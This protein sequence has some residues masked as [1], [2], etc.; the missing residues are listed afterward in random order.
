MGLIQIVNGCGMLRL[1]AVSNPESLRLLPVDYNNYS[2]Y[3]KRVK[4]YIRYIADNNGNKGELPECRQEDIDVTYSDNAGKGMFFDQ[5]RSCLTYL[6]G[7]FKTEQEATGTF[8]IVDN[9]VAYTTPGVIEEDSR[10]NVGL[11]NF[12]PEF[13]IEFEILLED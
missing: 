13:D 12:G 3:L 8:S 2:V 7:T 9:T 11:S 1:H 6:N 5:W 4:I 10:L